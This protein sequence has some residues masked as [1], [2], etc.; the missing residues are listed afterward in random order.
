MLPRESLMRKIKN[1]PVKKRAEYSKEL[2]NY[3]SSFHFPLYYEDTRSKAAKYVNCRSKNNVV[4]GWLTSCLTG[5]C[6]LCAV[7]NKKIIQD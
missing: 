4:L 1:W 5:I 7:G 6:R 3:A 2:A